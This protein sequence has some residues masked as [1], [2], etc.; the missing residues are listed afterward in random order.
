MFLE[1]SRFVTLYQQLQDGVYPGFDFNTDSFWLAASIN[2]PGEELKYEDSA[3]T[4]VQNDVFLK[5]G[6]GIG[7]V[8]VAQ[9]ITVED[10]KFT[11]TLKSRSDTNK[12]FCTFSM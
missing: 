11:V 6:G 4:P 2:A 9:A 3:K 1:D 10:Y 8:A 12:F 7:W 5:D